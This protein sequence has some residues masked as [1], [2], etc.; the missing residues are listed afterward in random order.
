MQAP[1][2]KDLIIF[3][4]EDYIA[5]NKPP[6]LS[7]LDDRAEGAFKSL[8]RMAKDYEPEAQVCHRLD[9]E[10]SGVLLIARN[11]EA[12][13]HS[14]MQFEHRQVTKRYHAVVGGIH[15]FKEVN[16]YLPILPLRTGTVTIDKVNGKEAETIFNTM[17]VYRAHTLVEC[18]PI[19]GRMH[20]IRIHLSCLKAP[21]VA[22]H[23]YGG[24]EIYLSE[25]KGKFKLKKNTEELPLIRRV[26]LHARALTFGLLNGEETTVEAEYPKDFRALISQLEKNK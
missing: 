25:I 11:P 24:D 4:S 18:K 5:I 19:T 7:T 8:L 21:I 1:N 17:E 14:S 2:F 26:A 10:T 16:V 9:K 12:Y 15:D 22:D 23:A 3:E 13:R 20:Q 6:Y